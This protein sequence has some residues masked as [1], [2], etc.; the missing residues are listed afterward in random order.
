MDPHEPPAAEASRAAAVPQPTPPTGKAKKKMSP[1]RRMRRLE[2]K[3]S[4]KPIRPPKYLRDDY[5]TSSTIM[6]AAHHIDFNT[7]AEDLNSAEVS[8]CEA[9]IQA[10]VGCFPRLPSDLR[11]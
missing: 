2:R 4:T 10:N 6:F 3:L 5:P 7:P 1:F 9:R 8:G 11:H